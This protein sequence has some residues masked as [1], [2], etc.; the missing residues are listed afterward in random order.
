MDFIDVVEDE[1]EMY[2]ELQAL[3]ELNAFALAALQRPGKHALSDDEKSLAQRSKPFDEHYEIS[4]YEI[5]SYPQYLSFYEEHYGFA[6]EHKHGPEWRR[7]DT[8]WLDVAETLALNVDTV[9]N[10]LSLV[11]AIEL[12]ES[13][14]VLLFVGDAQVGNW[15]SWLNVEFDASEAPCEEINGPNLLSRTVLYKVGHHGSINA[16]LKDKGLE[17]M[18]SD[19]LV[20]MIPVDEAFLNERL[21]TWDH[22]APRL[23]ERLMEKTGGRILRMDRIPKPGEHLA[24][25]DGVLQNEWDAFLDKVAWSDP[26][27]QMWIEYT[28]S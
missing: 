25:P 3:N 12:T 9:T 24:K 28:I 17:M 16:T 27:E 13:R 19:E 7:I 18:E 6:D 22:P 1:S 15:L 8:D 4:E 2:P 10:N 21:P 14:K 11:I 5:Y 23:Y 26:E 20:A